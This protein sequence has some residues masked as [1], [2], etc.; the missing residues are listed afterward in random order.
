[1][2]AKQGRGVFF[3]SRSRAEESS[4]WRVGPVKLACARDVS[5]QVVMLVETSVFLRETRC[6]GMGG[7]GGVATP[8]L[9]FLIF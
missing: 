3:L 9:L 2:T 8:P 6:A 4:A 1:M 5:F 7:V